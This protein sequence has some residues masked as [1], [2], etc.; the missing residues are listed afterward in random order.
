MKVQPLQTLLALKAIAM[1]PGL[2]ESDR[3]TGTALIE[4]FNRRT[5]RC[6]PS[7]GRLSEVTGFSERTVM[8]ATK[9]LVAAGLFR[10]DRHGGYSNRNSYEPAWSRLE[11][12]RRVWEAKFNAKSVRAGAS[13]LSPSLRQPCHL[14]GDAGVTQTY[15][16]NN[17]QNETCLGTAAQENP[18]AVGPPRPF[19]KSRASKEAVRNAAE[20]RWSADLHQQ[21]SSRP[22]LYG[23]V[24]DRINEQIRQ[25]ATDAEVRSHGAGLLHI[26]DELDLFNREQ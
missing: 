16:S 17:L 23:E 15:R 9:N 21:F 5:G 2:K 3:R 6:D 10:V 20:R 18:P 25:A 26:L 11:D 12:V 4:H 7:I 14:P 19:L 24:I 13:A 1:M 22:S 8:R